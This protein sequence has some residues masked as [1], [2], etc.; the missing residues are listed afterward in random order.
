MRAIQANQILN[1]RS[2]NA[3][4]PWQHVLEPLSGYIT[5]AER[6]FTDGDKFASAW[7]F[8]P[9]ED[10]AK[11]VSWIVDK[12]VSANQG[13]TWNVDQNPQPHE[14]N[15]LKLDSSKAKSL[16]QWQPKWRLTQ[17]LYKIIE[18]NNAWQQK[19]NMRTICEQQILE[20]TQHNPI[21]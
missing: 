3:I 15:Y 2:P 17:A 20:Y 5:L 21:V 8:G 6:L 11:P 13:A 9:N 4:R 7:N 12:L 14:A 16:L 10:D 19:A 1:I 18:W